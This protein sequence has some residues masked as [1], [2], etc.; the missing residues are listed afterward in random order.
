MEKYYLPLNS[1][2]L[3]HY[4]ASACI[5]PA[6]YLDNK[7]VDIQNRYGDYLFIIS[8]FGLKGTNCL[9][10]LV[11]TDVEKVDFIKIE[12]KYILYPK[13]LPISR[14]KNVYFSDIKQM[15]Q[16]IANIR[17]STAF[18]PE[19]ILA[20]GNH[21]FNGQDQEIIN[22][23]EHRNHQD[24]SENLK[25]FNSLMG[26]FA[27]MK[28]AGEEYMNYSDNYFS[29]LSFFNKEIK[30]EIEKYHRTVNDQYWDVFL[31]EK[32]FSKIYPYLYKKVDD[33]I[34]ESFAAD[35]GE[36]IERD[37]FTRIIN[38][39]KIE[40]TSVYTLAVLSTY[41]VGGEA[42]RKKID[43]LIL[44]NF[45]AEIKPEKSEGV[46]LC[47][48]LNRG[49]SVFNNQYKT[50]NKIR[51]VKF[52]LNSLLDYYTIESIYQ[53]SFN[54]TIS[55][56]FPYIETW[57]PVNLNR[58]IN[59]SKYTCKVLD[60][61]VVERRKP[62]VLSF[63]YRDKLLQRFFKTGSEFILREF[64]DRIIQIIYADAKEEINQNLN[65]HKIETEVSINIPK[66]ISSD[67]SLIVNDKV[68]RT[69]PKQPN[70]KKE[71]FEKIIHYQK[72]SKDEL[73]K[74]A[75]D[76]QLNYSRKMTKDDLVKIIILS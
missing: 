46:A 20:K 60:V 75:K 58:E 49:Y 54:G 55:D 16:T 5:M 33:S 42:R 56:K 72:F 24:Y 74:I 13:P 19:F 35:E 69:Q 10:E 73:I 14:V 29:T 17:L 66:V 32:G 3:A 40:K 37:K 8:E 43:G 36:T 23:P 64:T 38:I 67:S 76:K 9:L 39:N 52:Q 26:G 22:L 61:C 62:S 21:I 71:L 44:S 53:Y 7:P 59:S 34:L 2:S 50:G 47:Y 45:K 11:F 30:K 57:Y 1:Q 68:S 31:G 28:L 63:E 15:E 6:K 25:R 12:D 18:I 51:T 4:F 70:D 41:G 48:G 27:L 65:I